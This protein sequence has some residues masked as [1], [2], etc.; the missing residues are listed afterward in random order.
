[1]SNRAAESL[2]A[3][4]DDAPRVKISMFGP[5]T[6]E[7][8]NR[9]LGP[10]DLGGVKARKLFE[11]L[12][13][14]RGHP[15]PKDRL[16][17][18]LWGDNL[19]QNVRGC[20]EHY[21][22]VIR[23]SLSGGDARAERLVATESAAYRFRAEDADVDLD[24]F[25]ELAAQAAVQT[26]SER[27]RTLERALELVR[28]DVLEDEPYAPWAEELRE[29]Y[30]R[31]VDDLRVDA[32]E[33]ALAER[34]FRAALGHAQEAIGGDA[35]NERPYRAAMLALYAL[36]RQHHALEMFTRCRA[37]L[38]SELGVEPMQQTKALQLAILRQADPESLLASLESSSPAGA[39][40]NGAPTA[41]PGRPTALPVVTVVEAAVGGTLRQHVEP[42]AQMLGAQL[43]SARCAPQRPDA[44]EALGAALV[45]AVGQNGFRNGAFTPASVVEAIRSHAP[46][47][48][49]VEDLHRAEPSS[50]AVI[51]ELQRQCADVPVVVLASFRRAEVP[52]GHPL[53]A[54][55]APVVDRAGAGA[56]LL[57]DAAKTWLLRVAMPL[58]AAGPIISSLPRAHG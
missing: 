49:V 33:A 26:G 11:V 25:D 10:R 8:G 32:A 38:A 42:L 29:T 31:R 1:M 37:A 20:L 3:R 23:R 45:D 5:I 14:T 35:F 36:G 4:A 41:A 46:L 55:D 15:V 50:V 40:E 22:C 58:I 54:D 18:L 7:D 28:G 44:A 53:A 9:V 16:A 57:G 12:L 24:R 19:P 30:R 13:S 27:R 51:D 43:G 47:V 2:P 6:V 39:E 48:L 21:V 56:L 52:S 17:D 34:D